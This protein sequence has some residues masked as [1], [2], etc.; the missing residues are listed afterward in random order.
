MLLGLA[1]LLSLALGMA[2]GLLGGGGSILLLPVLVDVLHVEAE[3]AIALSLLVVAVTSAAAMLAHARAGRVAWGTGLTMGLAG[4][5]GAYAGGSAARFIPAG[6]LLAAFAILIL[7][8]AM[9]MRFGRRVDAGALRRGF[10]WLL[11]ALGSLFL[12]QRV[13][14]E[15]LR[16]HAGCALA[17]IA[18]AVTAH[19]VRNYLFARRIDHA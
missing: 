5:A 16:A 1:A 9:H 12:L 18:A 11:L 14:I 10:G 15:P 8:T 17:V 4:M 19:L 6:T 2:L 3:P 7:L 13:P